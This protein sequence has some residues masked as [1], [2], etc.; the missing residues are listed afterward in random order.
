M[1]ITSYDKSRKA[2]AKIIKDYEKDP[3]KDSL[4]F[5]NLIY[6]FSILL[7]YFKFEKEI[8][9]EKEIEIIKEKLGL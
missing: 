4:R 9:L 6:S 5:R 3:E 7:N 8:E 1:I 2:L